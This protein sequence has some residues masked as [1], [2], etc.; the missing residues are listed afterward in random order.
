[1]A[2]LSDRKQ[3]LGQALS[4]PVHR[5]RRKTAALQI[6][7]DLEI[8]LNEFRSPGQDNDCSSGAVERKERRS[9]IAA[10]SATEIGGES[11]VRRRISG[12]SDEFG[13]FELSSISRPITLISPEIDSRPER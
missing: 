10:V 1:M 3:S 2:L 9:K 8:F 5:G 4:T 7:Y 12:G 11:P 6:A 13:Y